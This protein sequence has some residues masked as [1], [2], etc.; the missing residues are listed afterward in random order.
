M[1]GDEIKDYS[2]DFKR[3]NFILKLKTIRPIKIFTTYALLF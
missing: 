3:F 1:N 2:W